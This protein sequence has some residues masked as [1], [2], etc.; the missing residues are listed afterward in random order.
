MKKIYFIT[1]NKDKFEIAGKVF[2]RSD[3]ELLQR[4]LDTPEI[5]SENLGEI[6][7]F[8]VKWAVAELGHPAFLTDA[9]CFIEA[10]KGFPG[11]FIKYVNNYLSSDDIIKL[12]SGKESRKVVF[13]DCLAYCE[14]GKEPV[15]FFSSAEGRI[16]QKA[17]QSG[18]TPIEEVFI[19]QGFD[20]PQSEIPVEQMIDFWDENMGNFSS[21]S[22]YLNNK[23]K[24]L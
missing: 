6:A 10:L 24:D 2:K 21:L 3:F 11:P 16:S 17:G 19:P 4:S 23:Q 13:K 20:K 15:L 12:M 22:K 7:S 14:P 1:N 18:K 5:Q 9:G 8:S